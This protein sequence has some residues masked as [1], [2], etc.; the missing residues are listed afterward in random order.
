[1][2][3]VRPGIGAGDGTQIVVGGDLGQQAL[4]LVDLVAVVDVEVTEVLVD[5]LDDLGLRGALPLPDLRHARL[6]KPV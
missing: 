1:M 5:L 6:G 3:E 4:D 2:G